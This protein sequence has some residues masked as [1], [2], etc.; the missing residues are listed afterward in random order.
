MV[1]FVFPRNQINYLECFSKTSLRTFR[2]HDD[3]I[4]RH[5][6]VHAYSIHNI[7]GNIGFEVLYE[8][9]TT[10]ALNY[11]RFQGLDYSS[12]QDSIFIKFG[13][14]GE[15]ESEFAL[16]YKPLEN[17]QMELSY[18]K[19]VNGFDVKVGSN[20]SLMSEIPEY[21]ANIEVSSTF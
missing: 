18:V 3:N 15:E 19:D 2:N 14:A 11:E 7:K 12:H 6:T 5:K 4:T 1:S 8:S 20:Y 13:H 10:F 17:N 21:G 9:G 16:N